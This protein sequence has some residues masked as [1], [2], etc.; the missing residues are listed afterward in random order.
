[1]FQR[2]FQEHVRSSALGITRRCSS[3]TSAFWAPRRSAAREPKWGRVDAAATTWM[4]LGAA[5][6]RRRSNSAYDVDRRSAGVGRLFLADVCP[7]DDP[8]RGRG[9]DATRTHRD[10]SSGRPT[11]GGVDRTHGR[12]PLAPTHRLVAHRLVPAAAPKSSSLRNPISLPPRNIHVVAAVFRCLYGI[13]TSWPRRRR[14]PPPRETSTETTRQPRRQS[15]GAPFGRKLHAGGSGLSPDAPEPMM[16]PEHGT[17]DHFA[18]NVAPRAAR[19]GGSVAATTTTR[20]G[21]GLAAPP[22]GRRGSAAGSRRRRPQGSGERRGAAAGTKGIAPGLA[23]P[24]DLAGFGGASRHHR[25]DD[26][27]CPRAR[28]DDARSRGR[29]ASRH[30]REQVRPRGGHR[31]PHQGRPRAV[32]SGQSLRRRWRR[33]FDLL[34][35][36]GR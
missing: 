36:P 23:T 34:E 2:A 24:P 25:G 18:I 16:E 1:M 6:R 7:A 12:L 21:R 33:V 4:R 29:D 15:Y 26:A 30:R 9:V 14:D 20:I 19:V 3:F 22:R 27:D 31:V 28:D 17:L 10:G 13:S 35:G 5:K 11:T 8:R 32:R